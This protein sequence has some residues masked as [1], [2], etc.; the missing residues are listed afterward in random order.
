[1]SEPNNKGGNGPDEELYFAH[2]AS[3]RILGAI[4]DL[5][6]IT[7]RLG[8]LP[9]SSHR[10]GELKGPKSKPYPHDMWCYTASVKE[11]EPLHVHIDALWNTFR[12]RKQYLLELK[13]NLTVD[14]FMGYS[15]NCQTA[16]VGLPYQ[17]LEIFRELQS[18]FELSI[19]VA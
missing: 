19:V 5:D 15:S 4:P 6:E 11:S 16:G 2:S 3:L 12:Q 10:R 1:M 8:V 17:S 7:R 9:T 13:E 14:V 18:R